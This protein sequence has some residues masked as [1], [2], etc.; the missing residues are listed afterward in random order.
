MGFGYSHYVYV[1]TEDECFD[2]LCV[3]SQPIGVP[4]DYLERLVRY[5]ILVTRVVRM[6]NT[7]PIFSMSSFIVCFSS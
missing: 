7:E 1:V 6:F 3:F 4:C 2:F 5:D